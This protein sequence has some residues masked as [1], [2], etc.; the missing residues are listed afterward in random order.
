[1]TRAPLRASA[2]ADV[3]RIVVHD[4]AGQPGQAQLSRA[5]AR[6][7]HEVIH[8]HC[9]SHLTGQGSLGIEPGDP[10]T[11]RFEACPLGTAL[12]RSAF[13]TRI[14]QEVAYGRKAARC[15]ID[16]RPD[17]AIV[18]NVP[19]LAH[20]ILAR[21]LSARGIPMV[22]WL[23]DIC[24]D[25]IGATVRP[26]FP[27]IA[28]LVAGLAERI[29]RSIARSSSGIVA[30]STS[31]L[32]ELR[33]WGVADRTTVVPN[34][35]PIDELPARRRVNAWSERMGLSVCPVVL[36]SGTLDLDHDPS[37]L[38]LISAQL[39]ESRPDARVVV[40]SEGKG[41][42]WLEKWKQEHRAEN[43]LLLDSQPYEDLPDVLASADVLV[44]I[45]KPGASRFSVPSEV[46]TYLWAQR[47]ILGV[48][49]RDNSMA[50]I[51]E[52]NEA[53]WVVDPAA[54]RG[55][56]SRVEEL[57]DDHQLR[58]LMGRDGRRYAE[59]EFSAQ[60]AADCFMGIFETCLP[61]PV[62]DVGDAVLTTLHPT[63]G[64]WTPHEVKLAV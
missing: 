54:R 26:R 13:L 59:T 9:P 58:R 48:I 5:L 42:Q 57:L 6:R 28:R 33:A 4:Y 64:P 41:R 17:V 24:P 23:Q 46:L 10:G 49:P 34:W 21:R 11:L 44:A 19:L 56:A 16:H 52:T 43:L 35:A 1:M 12:H 50:E 30:P 3:A 36:Y 7:G 40:I 14:R 63:S 53:G 18:S 38:A 20:A 25:A 8:Q 60:R 47:A 2:G 62:I 29:E 27:T 31:F 45:L 39:H 37:I 32:D 55:V 51:L 61:R 22:F 15:I